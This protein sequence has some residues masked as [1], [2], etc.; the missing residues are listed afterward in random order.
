MTDKNP[1]KIKNMFNL[2]SKNYDKINDII[3]FFMHRYA[4]YKAIKDLKILPNSKVLDLCSGSGDLGKIIKKLNKTTEI[5]G[6]DFSEEMI[7]SARKKNK[8]ITYELQ[9]A[10]NLSFKDNSFDYIVMGF[11]LR[12]IE[13]EQKA[14]NEIYRTLKPNGKFLHLDF[15]NKSYLNK[16]YDKIIIFILKFFIKEIDAYKYLIE[17]KNE[18]YNN[19]EIIKIFEKHN[20]KKEKSKTILFNMI[21]YQIMTK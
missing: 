10:T 21:A 7:K 6:V 12:N 14:L 19:K 15:N 17:S 4:K 8:N 9:D 1:N 3:S 2:I 11:G 5:I 20:F 13:D 16:I 18:F